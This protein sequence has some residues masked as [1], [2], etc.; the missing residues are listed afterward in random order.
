MARIRQVDDSSLPKTDRIDRLF[1]SREELEA[2]RARHAQA[3]VPFGDLSTYAGPCYIGLDAGSTTIKAVV[4]GETGE[5]LYSHYQNNEGSPLE[6]AK[7]IIKDIYNRL[8]EGAFIAKSGIT[9]YGEFLLKE[10]LRIDL[11]EVET[12]AHYQAAAH[13]CPD[14]DFILDIGGQDMKCCRLK[15]GHIEDILLNEACSAGCGSFLD[16]FAKSLNKSIQEFSEAAL[17]AEEP[18]DLGSRCTVFM[19]SKVKQ[20]QK[21]GS[22]MADISA[23]LSYSIIKMHSTRLLK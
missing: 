11:G 21:E 13:F 22:T 5:I 14:V 15:D 2:F 9:G 3:C 6:A 1:T 10:A 8:P 7:S 19:N 17:L 20:A 23:G 16:T 18:I 12:I 4:I